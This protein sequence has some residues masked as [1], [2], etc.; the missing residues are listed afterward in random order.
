[1]VSG[2]LC[3][4]ACKK[5]TLKPKVTTLEHN[6]A[7]REWQAT[8]LPRASLFF[9]KKWEGTYVGVFGLMTAKKKSEVLPGLWRRVPASSH[10]PIRTKDKNNKRAMLDGKSCEFRR[11]AD[12]EE[13]LQR[14]GFAIPE[15]VAGM[16]EAL[17]AKRKDET[18]SEAAA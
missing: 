5:A 8:D 1:M 4:D 16:E 17:Q 6:A 7:V 2:S 15:Q 3:I 12:L 10:N 13:S 14:L 11:A 9:N 18:E